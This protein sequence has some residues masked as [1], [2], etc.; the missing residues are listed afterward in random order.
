ME[1]RYPPPEKG[2]LSDSCAIPFENKAKRVR[3]PLC[4]AISKWY[5]AIW[6]GISHW[7]AKVGKRCLGNQSC[8]VVSKLITERLFLG[9]INSNYKYRSE[10]PDELSAI[11]ETDL[12]EFQ[13]KISHYRYRFS[14]EFQLIAITDTDFGLETN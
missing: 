6:G 3:Y 13:Q 2:Y 1:V 10:L 12:W 8:T 11:T 9:G 4:D 14:L 7:A 5:C